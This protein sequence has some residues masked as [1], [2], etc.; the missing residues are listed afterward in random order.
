MVTSNPLQLVNTPQIF[1]VPG[2]ILGSAQLLIQFDTA[3][4]AGTVTVERRA[5]GQTAW[6][7]LAKGT[8]KSITSGALA[9]RVDGVVGSI[10]VTFTGLTG[11][12]NPLLWIA[13][14][15]TPQGLFTGLAAVTTQ[16]YTE[17]NVKNGVQFYMRAVWP[18]A[19]LIV[20]GTTRK[21]FFQTG[22]KPVVIKQREF[23]YVSEELAINL[24]SNPVGVGVTGTALTIR[25]YNAVNPVA[26]TVTARVNVTTTSDGTLLDGPEYFFGAANAAQRSAGSIPQGRERIL[27]P[28]SSFLVTITASAGIGNSRAQYF[29]DWYEG[30]TDLPL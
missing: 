12:V 20:Q 6:T 5:P 27:A 16:P 13:P 24:Y 9:L 1:P 15:D 19:D 18:T 17:A 21:I 30:D 28:N 26:T 29:L 2:G 8:A 25:N 22:A 4:S 7:P 23:Q 10:R 14:V 3:P 11:G